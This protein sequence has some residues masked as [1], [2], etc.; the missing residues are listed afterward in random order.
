MFGDNE[1]V[2]NQVRNVN[3][4]KND[5]LKMYTHKFLDIIEGLYVFN[6]LSILGNQNKQVDKLATMGAKFDI[7]AEIKEL[8]DKN[9]VKILVR[10]LFPDKNVHCKLVE[11][12]E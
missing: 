5:L 4:T 11:S 9:Y 8:N 1:L 7:L 12:D 3:V 10:P 2:V 6:L